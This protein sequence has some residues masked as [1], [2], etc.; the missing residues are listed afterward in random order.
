[1]IPAIQ[2]TPG[3][4]WWHEVTPAV[5]E[6]LQ[7]QMRQVPTNTAAQEPESFEEKSAL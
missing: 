5:L 6:S 4:P 3:G 7:K 1:M 2:E